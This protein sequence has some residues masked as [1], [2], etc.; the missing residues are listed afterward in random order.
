MW[1][2]YCRCLHLLSTSAKLIHHLAYPFLFTVLLYVLRGLKTLRPYQLGVVGGDL[3]GRLLVS[4]C[5]DE[6]D[7]RSSGFQTM[8]PTTR[9]HTGPLNIHRVPLGYV[10]TFRLCTM[11]RHWLTS[12]VYCS[13]SQGA[14]LSAFCMTAPYCCCTWALEHFG[15]SWKRS[16]GPHRISKGSCRSLGRA[17]REK[18]HN[19][20]S[21][22]EVSRTQRNV[23]I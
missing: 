6:S 21:P 20:G 12:Q 23:L 19:P 18:P 1:G 11:C 9:W 14:A 7:L 13:Q 15:W 17:A 8:P 10:R 16:D 4:R 22:P 3:E 2:G 5:S